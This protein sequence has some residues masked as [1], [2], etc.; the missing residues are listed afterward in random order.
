M[1]D[2]TNVDNLEQASPDLLPAIVP[3]GN[4]IGGA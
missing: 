2:I 3:D 4:R 1:A